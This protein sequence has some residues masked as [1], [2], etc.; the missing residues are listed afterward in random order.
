M[1]GPALTESEQRQRRISELTSLIQAVDLEAARSPDGVETRSTYEQLC[2]H[3]RAL[4]ELL[5]AERM[6][7]VWAKASM[8]SVASSAS[9]VGDWPAA[10]RW[11]SEAASCVRI[12][13]GET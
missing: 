12:A 8:L 3:V 4:I 1:G 2:T 6:P 11:A 7:A 10:K 13:S 9:R 5:S